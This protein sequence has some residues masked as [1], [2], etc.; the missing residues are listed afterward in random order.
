MHVLRSTPA[1]CS[2]RVYFSNAIHNSSIFHPNNLKFW[3]KLLLT[4]MNNFPTG[5]FYTLIFPRYFL[6]AKLEKH[7]LRWATICYRISIKTDYLKRSKGSYR[8][9]WY[10]LHV[11]KENRPNVRPV[12]R[13]GDDAIEVATEITNLFTTQQLAYR[14]SVNNNRI[15]LIF[16]VKI[17]QTST[18][19]MDIVLT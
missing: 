19:F 15:A 4:Y 1:K 11:G 17:F 12:G 18:L 6:S 7:E 3:E 13:R 5:S 8:L 2:H 10:S 9:E 14:F 16:C